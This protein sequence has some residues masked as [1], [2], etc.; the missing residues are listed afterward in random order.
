MQQHL[1]G[2][3]V[4]ALLLAVASGVAEWRR[5]RRREL[6]SVGWVPWPLVQLLALLAAVMLASV[7]LN[8][9]Q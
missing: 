1:W 2:S 6:D 3:A 4:A 7:A 9:P 5:G 8:L